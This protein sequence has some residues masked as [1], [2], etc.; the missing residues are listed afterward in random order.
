MKIKCDYC[1]NTYEDTA[2]QCPGCGAPNPSHQNTSNPKTI[3]ELKKWYSDRN[4]PAPEVTR[5]FIGVDYKEPKA[6]GIFKDANGDFVVYKNKADGSRAIRYR[7][8][9]EEYAVNELLQRLKDEIVH[10]KNLNSN[11]G[12]NSF[13]TQHPIGKFFYKLHRNVYRGIFVFGILAVIFSIIITPIQNRHNG[14]YLY[15][16]SYYYDYQDNWYYYDDD[17]Y[18]V[19]NSDNAPSVIRSSYDD[20][21]VSGSWNNSIDATNWDNTSYYNEYHSSSS[22]Y[23][24]DSNDSW[25]SGGTDWGSD[26]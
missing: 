3:E 13:S 20:Y 24:W 5:F 23:D 10:Q 1:G 2:K 12:N 26:W 16:N 11:S 4:L 18:V 25:D 19:P 6:F 7:G 9:D 22:D 15:N 8:K 14:Y 21:Y 17:W